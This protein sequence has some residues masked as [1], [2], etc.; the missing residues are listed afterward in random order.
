[1]KTV[2]LK[3]SPPTQYVRF[4]TCYNCKS[5]FAIVGTREEIEDY[6]RINCNNCG[7]FQG[8]V[9]GFLHKSTGW[10]A[11]R[12]RNERR[13]AKMDGKEIDE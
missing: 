8:V 3:K 1:M 9:L 7:A 12:M 13:G 4:G 10:F 6:L 2:I 5:R 11:R